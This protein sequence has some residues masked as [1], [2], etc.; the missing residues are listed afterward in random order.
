M[1]LLVST[2]VTTIGLE[3]WIRKPHG[4]SPLPLLIFTVLSR[5]ERENIMSVTVDMKLFAEAKSFYSESYCN[6][7][8]LLFLVE[9]ITVVQKLLKLSKLRVKWN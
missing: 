4:Y 2:S 8:N 5:T 6:C 7:Y 9:Y 3:N 1:N